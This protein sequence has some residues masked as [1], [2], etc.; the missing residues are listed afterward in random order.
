[1]ELSRDAKLLR[2]F[3]YLF[4]DILL[5]LS[6]TVWVS[7]VKFLISMPLKETLFL[8]NIK[9]VRTSHRLTLKNKKTDFLTV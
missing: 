6:K 1:M 9:F 7:S 4:T 3:D 5:N 2:K 8:L